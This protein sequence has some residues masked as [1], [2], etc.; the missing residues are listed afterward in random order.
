MTD[1]F[2]PLP[3]ATRRFDLVFSGNMGYAPN[4]QAARWFVEE[5]LPLVRAS[6][7]EASLAIVGA[8]PLRTVRALGRVPGVHVTGYVDS[9]ARAL[10]EAAVA[11]APLRAASGIQNKVLEAMACGRPVVTTALG[12]GDIE[13]RPGDEVIVADGAEPFARAVVELL[14]SPERAEALGR[15]GRDFVVRRH[16]W[17]RAADAVEDVYRLVLERGRSPAAAVRA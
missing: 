9:V 16:S 14:R 8:R 13:A 15:R 10:N 4:A 12:L 11:V 17:E 3:G 2:A 5:C 6:V 1:E 7:P